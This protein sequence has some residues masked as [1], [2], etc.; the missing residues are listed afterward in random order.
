VIIDWPQIEVAPARAASHQGCEPAWS[1]QIMPNYLVECLIPGASQ[2][3][4][5]ELQSIAQ[6]CTLALIGLE[7]R[8]QWLYSVI[9][10]DRMVFLYIADDET[11][12]REHARRSGLPIQRISEVSSIIRPTMDAP[13]LGSNRMDGLNL[14]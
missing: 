14:K 10:A 13:G 8:I 7:T 11:A 5:L 3:M 12:V 2:L 6:Q 4:P 1:E 9:T